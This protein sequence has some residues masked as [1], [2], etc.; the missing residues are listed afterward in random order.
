LFWRSAS[1]RYRSDFYRA[2]QLCAEV[3]T[4]VIAIDGDHRMSGDL[5]RARS[6]NYLCD[7][8]SDPQRSA[9][10]LSDFIGNP[11]DE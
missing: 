10:V 5:E 9:K 3:L 8:Y 1:A 11:Q 4:H 2:C 6:G 7:R